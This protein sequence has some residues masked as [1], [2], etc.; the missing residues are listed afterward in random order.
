MCQLTIM[1]AEMGWEAREP[2]TLPAFDLQTVEGRNEAREHLKNVDP[3]FVA[4]APPCTAWS[5]MQRVNQR[6]PLQIRRL[7]CANVESSECC[8]PSPTR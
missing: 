7:Q 4:I 8:W 6:A 3:D 2:I 1:A 5:Q